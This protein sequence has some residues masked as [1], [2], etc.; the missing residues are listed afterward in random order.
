LGGS[1]QYFCKKDEKMSQ[2]T[3]TVITDSH[4]KSLYK[5]SGMATLIM[6]AL[7]PVQIIIFIAYPP[8]TTVNG[9]FLLFQKNWLIGLLSLDFLYIVNNILLSLIYLALYISLKRVNESFM[10]IALVLG[11]IGIT[12]YFPSNTAFEMLNLSNQYAVATTDV[13]RTIVQASG[14][15]MLAIYSGTTFN[16]Y[17]VLNAIALLIIATVM[18]QSDIFSKPTASWGIAAGVLM[19]IPS[20]AGTIGIAFALASLIPWSVFCVLITKRFFQLGRSM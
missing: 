14:Q 16:V 15:A 20:T 5:I 9:F 19:V 11:L 18:L 1:A 7:I 13:D 2:V 3:N 4:W 6:L 10:A 17:Y 12:A 8:P